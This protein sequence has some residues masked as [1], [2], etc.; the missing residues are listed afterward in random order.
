MK[1]IR[2]VYY[3]TYTKNHNGLPGRSSL[4]ATEEG[5]RAHAKQ[6][7]IQGYW[8]VIA[9]HREWKQEDQHDSAWCVDFEDTG[10][11]AVEMLGYF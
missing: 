5:A 3:C 8:G 9:R 6:L 10:E 4:F 2:M 1:M 7:I 11:R